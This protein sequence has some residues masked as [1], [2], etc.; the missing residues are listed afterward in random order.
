MK[1]FLSIAALLLIAT[2]GMANAPKPEADQAEKDERKCTEVR[3]IC[4]NATVIGE[5][6]TKGNT[7]RLMQ[8][9][10]EMADIACE[11]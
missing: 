10:K 2:A 6:C 5:V 7:E 11:E 4:D 1:R 3:I 9:V 8:K